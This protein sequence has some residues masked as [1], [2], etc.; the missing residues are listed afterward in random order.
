MSAYLLVFF[1]VMGVRAGKCL[2]IK[3]GMDM[4]KDMDMDMD[5]F[6]AGGTK[7]GFIQLYPLIW[8]PQ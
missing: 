6:G 1:G 3:L 7:L 5:F 4:D 2:V 8:L